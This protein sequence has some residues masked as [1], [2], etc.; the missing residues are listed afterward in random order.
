M[1]YFCIVKTKH[2]TQMYEQKLKKKIGF[3]VRHNKMTTSPAE[4]SASHPGAVE[5]ATSHKKCKGA[6]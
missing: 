1:M 4:D 5:S 3:S 2:R 6:Y